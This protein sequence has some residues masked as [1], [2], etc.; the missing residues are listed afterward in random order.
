MS[1]PDKKEIIYLKTVQAFIDSEIE[2]LND[3]SAEL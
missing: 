1:A 2:S 3:L